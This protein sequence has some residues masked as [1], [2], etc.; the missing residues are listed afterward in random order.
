M[1]DPFMDSNR[2]SRAGMRPCYRSSAYDPIE[3]PFTVPETPPDSPEKENVDPTINVLQRM[4]AREREP[5]EPVL[6]ESQ[7]TSVGVVDALL[8]KYSLKVQK[9]IEEQTEEMR[10]HAATQNEKIEALQKDITR[11]KSIISAMALYVGSQN[12]AFKNLSVRPQTVANVATLN[13]YLLPQIAVKSGCHIVTTYALEFVK[14]HASTFEYGQEVLELM[15]F[16]PRANERKEKRR[17]FYGKAFL[18]MRYGLTHNYVRNCCYQAHRMVEERTEAANAHP[19]PEV[20]E[21]SGAAIESQLRAHEVHIQNSI[22]TE[23]DYINDRDI[24]IACEAMTRLSKQPTDQSESSPSSSLVDDE[25]A[26]KKRQKVNEKSRSLDEEIKQE[27]LKEMWRKQTKYFSLARQA[28][29]GILTKTIGFLF[30][31]K[32]KPKWEFTAPRDYFGK[33]ENVVLTTKYKGDNIIEISRVNRDNK[34]KLNQLM[35]QFPKLKFKC[36]YEVSIVGGTK[37]QDSRRGPRKVRMERDVCI[38]DTAMKFIEMYFQVESHE[39]FLRF[40]PESLRLVYLIAMSIAVTL[41]Q[42]SDILN[43]SNSFEELFSNRY[44]LFILIETPSARLKIIN[45]S[46]L[47]ISRADFE[48]YTG[49]MNSAQPNGENAAAANSGL[50]SRSVTDA[51]VL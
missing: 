48:D 18:D 42:A 36:S 2:Q 20:A 7:G 17:S 14:E 33:V 37:Q 29:R 25:N 16:S 30:E 34:A 5:V 23:K 41:E 10:T 26:R 9:W 31:A 8:D 28:S 40:V 11:N 35:S 51:D 50:L 24:R 6:A 45:S 27:V 12:V 47:N 49:A 46:T 4:H 19:E 15:L 3:D 13:S 43:G 22:W 38:V 39:D 21:Q 44:P 32:A 1:N